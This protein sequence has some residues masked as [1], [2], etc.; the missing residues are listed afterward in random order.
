MR[1]ASLY[2]PRLDLSYF[3]R[4]GGVLRDD[5]VPD[6]DFTLLVTIEAP[7]AFD[8]YDRIRTEY[9]VLTP[10]DVRVRPRVRAS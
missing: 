2:Q 7:A 3:A 10:I 1:V 5:G 6:L 4:A 9:P 8:L